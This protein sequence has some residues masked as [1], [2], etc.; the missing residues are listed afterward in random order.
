M[1]S[2]LLQLQESADAAREEGEYDY[3]I[4]ELT[5]NDSPIEMNRDGVRFPFWESDSTELCD[6]SQT[7]NFDVLE[8]PEMIKTGAE[9]L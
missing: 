8:S 1:P 6:S 3:P 4:D 9:S 7:V 2:D 5:C